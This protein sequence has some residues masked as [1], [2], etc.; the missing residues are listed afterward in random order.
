MVLSHS[1][2]PEETFHSK[3]KLIKCRTICGS[4]K[5]GVTV[6]DGAVVDYRYI[7]N[8]L[9]IG[10]NKMVGQYRNCVLTRERHPV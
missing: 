6:T 1:F 10:L 8:I 3:L 9:R 4:A 7:E 2:M 5:A